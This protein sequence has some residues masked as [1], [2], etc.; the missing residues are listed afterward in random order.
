ME[1]NHNLF[2]ENKSLLVLF[3]GDVL[4]STLKIPSWILRK[5]RYNP[6]LILNLLIRKY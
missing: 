3:T 6:L 2:K 5:I 1:V 4:L